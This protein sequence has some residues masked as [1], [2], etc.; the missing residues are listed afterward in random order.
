MQLGT[1]LLLIFNLCICLT[2]NAQD[3]AAIEPIVTDRPDFTESPL[4]VPARWL[5]LESGLT[6]Q[7][8]DHGRALSGPEVLFRYG[9]SE[10]TEL[11][12]G[13][14]DYNYSI[15]H[16]RSHAGFGDTYLGVKYR[17]FS[18]KDYGDIALIPA[19]S[20]PSDDE[21]F[22]SGSYD[23]ELKLTWSFDLSA[24]WSLSVMTFGVWTSEDGNRTFPV[25]QTASLGH[26]LS[27][28]LAMFLEY[29]GTFSADDPPE[30]VLHSGLAYFITR[31]FVVDAHAGFTVNGS[32]QAPFVACGFAFRTSQ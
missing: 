32:D 16:A 3:D 11:R 21:T 4:T 7:N 27:E 30:H 31:D 12:L 29:A 19:V 10:S 20:I 6:F 1:A 5:Q 13:L 2:A 14:P 8:V 26:Q 28:T 17:F 18:D 23:P 22:S 24:S 9:T 15:S 25:Q